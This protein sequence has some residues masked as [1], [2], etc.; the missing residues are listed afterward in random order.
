[1]CDYFIGKASVVNQPGQLSLPSL[2]SG[3]WVVIHVITWITG[4]ETIKRQTRVAYGWL[5][6]GQSVD[7]GLAYSL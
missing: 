2:R 5:V 6:V 3:K 1:M 7:A 4:V